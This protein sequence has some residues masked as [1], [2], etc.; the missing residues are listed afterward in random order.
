MLPA[1]S[2][3][4]N[5]PS[6]VQTRKWR[7]SLRQRVI[8]ISE[9]RSTHACPS[10]DVVG[11]EGQET[12]RPAD[13]VADCAFPD[14]RRVAAI[15]LDDEEADEKATVQDRQS[16]R[17]CV[18]HLQARP[19]QGTEVT[20]SSSALRRITVSRD[21]SNPA[22][23]VGHSRDSLGLN[24]RA[25]GRYR[26]VDQDGCIQFERF[27]FAE[28]SCAT[29]WGSSAALATV[30]SARTL[31]WV[32]PHAGDRPSVPHRA[33]FPYR[34]SLPRG[35][36]SGTRLVG[37]RRGRSPRLRGRT[38]ARCIRGRPRSLHEA[39]AAPYT[40]AS[41]KGNSSPRG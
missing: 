2:L 28:S 40:G 9:Q 16:H 10:S 8:E 27:G 23:G 38:C 26:T 11:R 32:I 25:S 37:T 12:E 24:R 30:R 22:S 5:C 35:R 19:G 39:E 18:V 1:T 3:L 15:V 14:E 20:R 4:P 6:R 34:A 13:P 33:S 41:A 17:K 31:H 7:I 29:S 36:G 21:N